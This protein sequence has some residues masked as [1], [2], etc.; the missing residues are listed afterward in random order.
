MDTWNTR[1]AA[2]LA[3]SDY[4][5]NAL[6]MT[7]GV[8]APTVSAWLG[9]GTIT[10]A[11]NITAENALRLCQL[12]KIRPEWLLFKEGPMRPADAVNISP[13]MLR[14]IN[15]LIAIDQTKDSIREDA[16]YFINRLLRPEN[17]S[18]QEIGKTG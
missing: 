14:L 16:I 3:A 13:E 5:A 17:K 12:L 6:A 1:L 11:R 10:P 15:E 2:A 7:L 9:A 4:T 8:S 18:S